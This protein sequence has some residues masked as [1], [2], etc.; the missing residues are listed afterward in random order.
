MSIS[1]PHEVPRIYQFRVG[2]VLTGKQMVGRKEMLG[3]RGEASQGD[4]KE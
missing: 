2:R 1:S 4:V 3:G